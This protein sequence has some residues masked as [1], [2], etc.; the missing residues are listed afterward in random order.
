MADSSIGYPAS[1]DALHEAT[2]P[3]RLVASAGGH[4]VASSAALPLVDGDLSRF[5]AA[6]ATAGQD[7]EPAAGQ[8]RLGLLRLHTALL[9]DTVTKAM[10][11]LDG[12]TADGTSLLSR[13][14]IQGALAD[15]AAEIRECEQMYLMPG[16]PGVAKD[17]LISQRLIA[18][19]RR[20]LD[21]FGARGFLA[22]GPAV[23]LFLAEVTSNVY[24]HPGTENQ[25]A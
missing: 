4:V 8:F 16:P 20:L 3:G 21:L 10:A 22:D 2:A 25:D 9:R 7:T 1:L 18:T 11:T 6:W 13:Q 17:W 14:L 12:R 15:A 24:L 23:D 19:G 5:G